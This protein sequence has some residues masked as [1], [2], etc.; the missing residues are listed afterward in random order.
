MK[1][2]IRSRTP[3]RPFAAFGCVAVLA[4]CAHT[5]SADNAATHDAVTQALRSKVDTIVVIYAE[6]R[7]FDTFYG[8]FPGANGISGLNPS[9][10]GSVLPQRDI[11]GAVLPVLPPVWGGLTAPGQAQVV[12]QAQTV[13]ACR[14]G[15]FRSTA[16]TASTAAVS[17]CRS[18]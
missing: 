10:V 14:T 1:I 7:A 2:I 18:R 9:A 12:T 3:W 11:D 8:P 5:D 6:N 13:T 17:P 16:P 15:R 4:A